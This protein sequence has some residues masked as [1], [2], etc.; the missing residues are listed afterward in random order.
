MLV[1]VFAVHLHHGVAL[2]EVR[3]I[4]VIF[5]GRL[6]RRLGRLFVPGSHLLVFGV[7][8]RLF[9][10]FGVGLGLG[11][12]SPVSTLIK[13]FPDRRGMATGM[14]IM[15]FGGG[16]MI[17]TPLADLLMR[18]FQTPAS[19]GVWETFAVMG[20]LYFAAMMAGALAYRLPPPAWTP[21]GWTP[22]P[23][24]VTSGAVRAVSALSL[25]HISE[26]TRPY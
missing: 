22:P 20:A 8:G 12:M 25:I 21:A 10:L 26:P 23:G 17:G 3:G 1:D 4:S 7:G 15:G 19:V 16:A 14:A 2:G 18:Y 24:E 13:W 5:L 6:V 11:Y 9:E